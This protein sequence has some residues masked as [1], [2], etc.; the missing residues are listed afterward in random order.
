M[1]SP[2]NDIHEEELSE[3]EGDSGREPEDVDSGD[4]LRRANILAEHNDV[5]AKLKMQVRD[6]KVGVSTNYGAWGKG[7]QEH[8]IEAKGCK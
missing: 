8:S 6:I 5:L 2:N 7:M 3:G 1:Q 4:D